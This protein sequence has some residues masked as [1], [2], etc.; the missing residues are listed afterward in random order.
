MSGAAG[1][2]VGTVFLTVLRKGRPMFAYEICEALA[3]GLPTDN[4]NS[5]YNCLKE[6]VRC[7]YVVREGRA[8]LYRY[9]VTKDCTAPPGIRLAD[10]MEPTLWQ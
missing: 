1:T 4:K 2:L 8:R 10:L 9:R 3:D 5:L 7:G 6:A